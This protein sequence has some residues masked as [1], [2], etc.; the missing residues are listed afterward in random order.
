MVPGNNVDFDTGQSVSVTPSVW[1][2]S[3]HCLRRGESKGYQ[4]SYVLRVLGLRNVPSRYIKK[5]AEIST[6]TFV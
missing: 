1:S 4:I 2:S 6:F 3:V 5:A